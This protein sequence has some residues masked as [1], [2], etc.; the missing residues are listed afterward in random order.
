MNPPEITPEF[1]EQYALLD[2]QA[3][4]LALAILEHVKKNDARLLKKIAIR[5]S[6]TIDD[7]NS[8][9]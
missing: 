4:T 5:L 3:K 9:K 6:K 2:H 1:E 7:I 8:I